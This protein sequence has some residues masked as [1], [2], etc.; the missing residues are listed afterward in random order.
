[1][2]TAVTPRQVSWIAHTLLE[3]DGLALSWHRE[4]Q[5]AIGI[6]KYEDDDLLNGSPA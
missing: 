5:R 6:V 4:L 3:V 2:N 1:V